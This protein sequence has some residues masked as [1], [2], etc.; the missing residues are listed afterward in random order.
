[1]IV[2]AVLFAYVIDP[3][4]QVL[5]RKMPRALAVAVVY[6]G[7]VAVL[8]VAGAYLAPAL[9]AQASDFGRD[10]PAIVANLQTQIAHPTDNPLMARFP[11][12]IRDQIA[13]N[14]GEAG[15]YAG[16]AAAAVGGRAAEIVAGTL[17]ALVNVLLV[18]GLAFFFITDV[19][20]IR[21]TLIRIFPRDMRANVLSFTDECGLVIGGYV[22]G[23]VLM[24][25]GVGVA[26]TLILAIVH[27]QFAILLGMF[28]GVAS[29]VPI[30]GAIVG[31][32]PAVL[33]AL[34]T[35]GWVKALVVLALFVVIFELQGHVLTPVLIAK[36]VGVTPL[37]VFVAL[38]V[39][40]EAF[41]IL[42]MLLAIP[43]A[44]ILRVAMARA[45]P[46]DPKPLGH[47]VEEPPAR[48]L[49]PPV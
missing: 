32:V 39:G 24:A 7:I 41:G 11:L 40:E 9:A 14:A 21:A 48:V 12:P 1:V 47:V 44:G 35:V 5:A 22:R 31:A 33:V 16:I 30:V 45:F 27:V 34:V 26:A 3:P 4:V 38:L 49:V 20:Q 19:E 25:I 13:K 18:F 29:I 17:S 36:A 37:V 23:Q 2:F 15:H 43:L 42:G 6:L 10:Y 28:T 8:V 46:E